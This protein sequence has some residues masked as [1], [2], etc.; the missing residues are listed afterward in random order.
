MNDLER[1]QCHKKISEQRM[2]IAMPILIVAAVLTVGV[3]MTII[4]LI[5]FQ[6]LYD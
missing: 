6:K 2:K 3:I 5:I 4:G 1:M